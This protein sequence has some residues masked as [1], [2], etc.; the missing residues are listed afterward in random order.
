MKETKRKDPFVSTLRNTVIAVALG[1]ITPKIAKIKNQ[2]TKMRL[3]SKIKWVVVLHFVKGAPEGVL[4]RCT[5]Y[6]FV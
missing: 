2:G 5:H 6:R 1:I 4:D 3:L